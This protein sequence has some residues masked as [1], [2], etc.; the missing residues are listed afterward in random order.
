MMPWVFPRTSLCLSLFVCEIKVSHSFLIRLREEE[1]Q[2]VWGTESVL[3]PCEA[4]TIE[5]TAVKAHHWRYDMQ[6]T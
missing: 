1:K 6:N 4:S 5:L 2:A 3:H